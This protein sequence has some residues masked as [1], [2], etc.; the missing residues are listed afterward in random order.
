MKDMNALE[1]YWYWRNSKWLDED[2]KKELISIEDNREEIEERFCKEL[3]FGTG[4]LRGILGAGTNRINKYTVR[5]ATQ[6]LSRYICQQKGEKKGV[7]IAYDS[8]NYSQ[9]FAVE[10]ALCLNANG[11]NSYIFESLRPTPEL[12]Y[13]LRKLGCIAGVVITAS[14][15]PSQYNGYKVYWEDGAQIT[16]PR[17]AEIINEVNLVK[18]YQSIQIMKK[19]DAIKKGLYHVIGEEI[20][21]D[22]I[23]DLKKLILHP[24]S[25]LNMASKL[26]IVYTPLHGS[27]NKPIRRILDELGFKQVYIVKEQEL[28][29]GNFSTVSYPNPEKAEVFTL[30][31]KLARKVDADIILATDPDA[32]RLGVYVKDNKTG[33]YVAFNG[34]MSGLLLCEYQLYTKKKRGILPKNGAI[35]STIVSSDMAKK[36]AKE[37]DV[38][39]IET[40]TGFKYIGE[41]IKIFEEEKS[42]E[43][44]FGFEESF[45]CL[46]GTCVRDKDAVMTAMAMCEAAAF[47]KEHNMTLVDQMEEIYKKYGCYKEDLFT[48]TFHAVG[49]KEWIEKLIESYRVSIPKDIA[50]FKVRYIYDYEIRKKYNVV[51]NEAEKIL[52]PASNVLY[53]ELEDAWFCIRPSGTEPKIKY[54]IGVKGSTKSDATEKIKRL[55]EA[56]L[57]KN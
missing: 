37:Y 28:P 55:K 10:T 42:F 2:S 36:M 40:L 20:D 56:V 50:G 52:L 38:T 26:K 54:Y 13:A 49:G 6:G 17:D 19:E 25:I 33:E 14:H 44:L 22:Y 27:G 4:G 30:A 53:Y 35:I 11:I 3:E 16:A 9:E 47:Y 39:L 29:D 46:L 57:R 34:N 31:L 12:S 45:G 23:E 41:Q 51:T 1:K 32:D 15:N 8:R 24:E 43:F 48:Q 5:K 7:A 18:E 21:K